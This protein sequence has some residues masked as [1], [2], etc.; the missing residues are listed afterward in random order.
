MHQDL[1]KKASFL[2][3][4]ALENFGGEKFDEGVWGRREGRLHGN[5]DS[6]DLLIRCQKRKE[7]NFGKR[8]N[9][10]C[11]EEVRPQS[12]IWVTLSTR[13]NYRIKKRF[14]R[15]QGIGQ[16]WEYQRQKEGVSRKEEKKGN[17]D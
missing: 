7:R 12:L 1:D 10:K 4:V 3:E 14:I 5:N 2:T 8:I 13:D 17:E 11:F 15:L 6:S 9:S 16:Y